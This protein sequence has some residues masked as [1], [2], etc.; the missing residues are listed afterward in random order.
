MLGL[1]VL[2]SFL[3]T[4]EIDFA[5][6]VADLIA[7]HAAGIGIAVHV[8]GAHGIDK[9]FLEPT[10]IQTA[11]LPVHVGFQLHE[12]LRGTLVLEERR[13]GG[14]FLVI[15]RPKGDRSG[16]AGRGIR[17]TLDEAHGDGQVIVQGRVNVRIGIIA[18]DVEAVHAQCQGLFIGL[19]IPRTSSVS[20][21]SI[22]HGG[23]SAFEVGDF[24]LAG[25]IQLRVQ[26]R[27]QIVDERVPVLDV[28]IHDL[29]HGHHPLD[30]AHF[31]GIVGGIGR[32]VFLLIGQQPTL[33][34]H[35]RRRWE[36]VQNATFDGLHGGEGDAGQG[37]FPHFAFQ[38]Q[39]FGQAHFEGGIGIGGLE[40][41]ATPLLGNVM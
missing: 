7:H 38:A 40:F 30:G 27:H 34:P 37:H 26:V 21:S 32:G 9:G 29:G 5:Q 33:E 12:R 2:L 6:D 25:H 35:F 15:V 8:Q 41:L 23:A 39:P 17:F 22:E 20:P 1:K 18:R 14:G 3:G 36:L 16:W 19:S 31:G 4:V 11:D 24:G 10:S 13:P 28:P